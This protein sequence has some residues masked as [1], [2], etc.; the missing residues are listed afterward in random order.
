[1]EENNLEIS[2]IIQNSFKYPFS[3]IK[4]FLILGI[5]NLIMAILSIILGIQALSISDFTSTESLLSSP[6]FTTL[7]V[8]TFI[9]LIVALIVV[10]LM[11]GIGLAVIRETIN[12]SN[13]LPE[14]KIG[15]N[16]LDGIKSII[17]TA[18]YFL[19]P[20]V[21]FFILLL[22]VGSLVED[23][24]AI[25]LLLMI[26]YY[27]AIIIVSLFS[28]V[29]L[30]RLAETNSMGEALK[31]LNIFDIAKS[32]GLLKI[33]GTVIIA[34]IIISIIAIVSALL[35]I[36]PIIGVI[37]SQYI[38]F[39]FIILFNC[40]LEGLLYRDRKVEPNSVDNFQ[41]PVNAIGSQDANQVT[42]F[43]PLSEHDNGGNDFSVT[44]EDTS[45][46]KKCSQC[47]YSNPDFV[48]IC[49]NCGSEL[50]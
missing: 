18:I 32:I 2:N 26:I 10:L 42:D 40:R 45:S 38:I 7:L 48:N 25:L 17:I 11:N 47:G 23:S 1:M 15:K 39:T 49:I 33:F 3:D 37:V 21:I 5:P 29:A 14:I 41:Q 46:V 50:K 13:E 35:E 20:T 9:Y 22:I 44:S 24:S 12:Y 28:V 31:F 16:I 27:I 8:T 4:K 43:Q 30:G 6:L 34:G 19:V 36:I